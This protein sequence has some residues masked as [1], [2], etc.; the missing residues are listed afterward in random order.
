MLESVS[1]PMPMKVSDDHGGSNSGVGLSNPAISQGRRHMLD[2]VNRLHSTGVQV[3]I[4][5]P[6]IAVIGSQSAG[7]SSLI[8]S[9]SGITLPRA[10]GTCTRCPTECKLSKSNAPWQCIVSLRY[11]TDASGQ[12]LGQA[13]N[14]VFGS[15]I[16]DKSQVEDR[17]RRAQLAIL[18]PNKPLKYFL[19]ETD[20]EDLKP[21][22]SFSINA[23]SLQISGPDVADLSFVDLPGLIASQASGS[24]DGNDIALVQNLVTTYIKK[25]NC[26]ILLTVACET[27][28][29]NQ[30]AHR[31]TKQYD[32]EG[33]RTIGVLTK[34]DRIPTGEESNWI[35]FIRNEKE[36]LENG[37]FCVKQPS[38]HE[39][40]QITTWADVRQ[41]ENEFFSAAAPWNE[42]DALY[43]KHLRTVNLVNRLSSVLSDLIAK[44]LPEI[45]NEL[46]A[47]IN[48]CRK[49]LQRLPPPPPANPQSEI[50][51]LVYNFVTDLGRHVEGVPDENGLLQV[52]RPAQERFR[53]AIR[54]TAPQFRPFERKYE[55]QRH[56]SRAEFLVE[57]EGQVWD[58]EE[59]EDE[60]R[61]PREQ[62]LTP[63]DS[64]SDVS[65]SRSS[66][67]KALPNN[68]I[69]ID[70]VMER[71]NRARTRELPGHFPYVVQKT[72]IESVIKEWR[73]PALELCKTVYGSML[74]HVQNLVEKHFKDF[75]QG[76]LEHSIRSIMRQHIEQCRSNA[77]NKISWLLELEED[78]FSLNTH[79]F[80]DY[81]EK[82]LAYY[83]GERQRYTGSGLM[84]TL[85]EENNP[86]IPQALAALA[87]L[88]LQGLNIIDL[89]KLLPSDEME[90][91]LNIMSDVRAYFQVAY[92]RFADNVP[93]SIDREL[94]KG[95]T[96]DLLKKI[97]D[98][99]GTNTARGYEISKEFALESPQV[100]DRRADL[101]KKLERL[102]SAQKQLSGR[103]GA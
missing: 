48:T 40:K 95:L 63:S 99:L 55:E 80:A 14:P 10:A 2:L 11:I 73:A 71:A 56:I 12:V 21:Q 44:R 5:L 16:Y 23:V 77:E 18:N 26:I 15:V 3:D 13:Q 82:F 66:K 97:S 8:E 60:D 20:F 103:L 68:K 54:A 46:D 90:P 42:L 1:T 45:F 34:P 24:G 29:E 25:P 89:Q 91:A 51:S 33:K 61:E 67:R 36:P 86:Q 30:G 87:A 72:F 75:G 9:I 69:Y 65:S 50:A 38:S 64:L 53:R 70:D 39:L 81:K 100:A 78:P 98:D 79:Y 62:E 27:D 88:G 22:L 102:E 49:E 7:K 92:K 47:S 101:E 6:Q 28:F 4:D 96:R 74:V 93:L 41:K 43:Q 57:E 35:P 31:L 58:N 85:S 83:K 52:I 59:S 19:E 17:I 84:S 32:P 94:V 37:W 76:H